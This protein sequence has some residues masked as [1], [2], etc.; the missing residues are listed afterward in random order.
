MEP[1]HG[2]Q[3]HDNYK[4][5]LGMQHTYCNSSDKIWVF[6]EDVWKGELVRDN[7]QCLTIKFNK[8]SMKVLI[9]T[10]YVRCDSLERLELWDK[11]E[12]VAKV[13][14]LMWIVGGDFNII[15]N[16]EKKQRRGG[17]YSIR[18]FGLQPMCE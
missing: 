1:F 10:V 12:L 4:M 6:W 16:E 13:N 14:T 11:L 17:F 18:S 2:P 15:L 7:G 9:T 5:K 8:N 3:E